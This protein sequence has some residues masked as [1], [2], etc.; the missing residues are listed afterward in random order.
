MDSVLYDQNGRSFNEDPEAV[1]SAYEEKARALG[2]MLI[3]SEYVKEL[4]KLLT[5][6]VAGT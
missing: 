4:V 2:G 6:Q 1:Q 3:D 5:A